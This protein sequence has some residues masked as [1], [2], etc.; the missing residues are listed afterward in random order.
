LNN[1][2]VQLLRN[3]DLPGAIC[4]IAQGLDMM[5]TILLETPCTVETQTESVVDEDFGWNDR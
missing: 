3:G 2:G 4:V 5:K 1:R